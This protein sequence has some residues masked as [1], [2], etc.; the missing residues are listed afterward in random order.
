[1]VEHKSKGQNLEKAFT[2]SLD[3]TLNLNDYEFPK[4]IIV[5]DFKR[6]RLYDLEDN[7]DIEFELKELH[8]NIHLFDFVAGY[9]KKTYKEEDP[10]NIEAAE[11]MGHTS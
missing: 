3:Y 4:Y 2:Q 10:A 8:K 1:M 5:S 9:K 7:S 11:L 6:L